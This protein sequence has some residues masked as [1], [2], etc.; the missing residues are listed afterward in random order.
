VNEFDPLLSTRE[1]MRLLSDSRSGLYAKLRAG[2]L[3]AVKEG[4][5][6]KIRASELRR[7]MDGLPRAKY[8]PSCYNS[9]GVA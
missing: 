1:A 3:T 9:N 6:R 7:Y 2:A 4:G 8:S 5:S